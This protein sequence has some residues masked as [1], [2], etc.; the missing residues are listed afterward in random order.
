MIFV[1]LVTSLIGVLGPIF[2]APV[3][4]AKAQ[5]VLTILKQFGTGI[6]ISTA[7]IHVCIPNWSSI[8]VLTYTDHIV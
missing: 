3:L 7:L 6:I 1:V 4:P 2:V 5:I 8:Y